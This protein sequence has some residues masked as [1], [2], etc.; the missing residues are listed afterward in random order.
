MHELPENIKIPFL[1][2]KE[3]Q[4]ELK[5]SFPDFAFTLDGKLIGDIGE[6]LVKHY[7]KD[8]NK[9][10]EGAH[11]HDF[12][13][14]DGIK[15]QVKA[16]QKNSVGM[17]NTYSVFEHLIV[18]FLYENGMFEIIY[19]GPGRLIAQ[20]Y[21]PRK[22]HIKLDILSRYNNHNFRRILPKR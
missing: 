13:N 15:I 18:L 5:N 19:D 22:H 2:L 8:L 14:S 10:R 1:R 4:Q 3:A 17:G 21:S 12:I 16:T 6:V 11:G 7:C 9:L 20:L